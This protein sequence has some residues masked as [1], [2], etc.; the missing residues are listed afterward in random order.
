M[1][2]RI[3]VLVSGG[4]TNLQALI[5][6]RRAG[7]FLRRE[8]RDLPHVALGSEPVLWDGR[9]RAVTAAGAAGAWV[10]LAATESQGVSAP[11]VRNHAPAALLA[12][13]HA[14]LRC[15]GRV[16]R[17]SAAA[18]RAAAAAVRRCGIPREEL[19]LVSKLPGRHQRY[20]EAVYTLEES[21]M[22]AGLDYWD[23]YLIHWPNPKHGLYVEAFQALLEARDRGLYRPET[24]DR[25]FA[26]PNGIRTALDGNELWQVA[27]LEM[28]LQEQGV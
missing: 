20:D 25:L 2:T 14:R 1:L 3:A 7:I 17:E 22:R 15:V 16:N 4:G 26:N 9:L 10:F 28:W 6:A 13:R 5:D 27:L 21:L 8:A 23:M 11:G 19:R 24:L 18:S 12:P